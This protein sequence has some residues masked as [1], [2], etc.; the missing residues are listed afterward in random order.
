[1]VTAFPNTARCRAEL[2][3]CAR[4]HSFVIRGGR[5]WASQPCEPDRDTFITIYGAEVAQGSL[6]GQR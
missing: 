2:L 3:A 6:Y 1:M 5:A 4:F